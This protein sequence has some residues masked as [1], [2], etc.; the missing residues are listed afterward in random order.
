MSQYYGRLLLL[1]VL[2]AF[3]WLIG[4][5]YYQHLLIL[6]LLWVAIGSGW[7]LISGYTGQVLFGAGAFF[8]LGAYA[9]ALLMHK[10]EISAWWGLAWVRFCPHYWPFLSAGSVFDCVVRTSLLRH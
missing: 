1:V 9:A 10:L 8:G 7:N 2:V 4:D 6:F 5:P 3:P